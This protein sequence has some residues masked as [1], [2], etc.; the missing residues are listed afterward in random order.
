M[1]LCSPEMEARLGISSPGKLCAKKPTA[2][3]DDASAPQPG[4]SAFKSCHAYHLMGIVC[5]VRGYHDDPRSAAAGE[6]AVNEG[7][8]RSSDADK[9]WT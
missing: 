6:L 1:D 5:P 7:T 9:K 3:I 2:S 8:R 4:P